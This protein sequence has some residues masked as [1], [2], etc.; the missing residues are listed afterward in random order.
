MSFKFKRKE[1]IMEGWIKIYRQIRNHWIWKDKEPFDKRSA[2]IDLLLSVNH[3][4]KKVPFENDFIEIERGQTLTSIKQLA[5]RWSWSR[6]KVSDY[7]NQLEQDTMIVQVR[8]TRKTLISIVNY[9][10]YQPALEE[11]DILGDTLRDRLG[12]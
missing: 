10:K 9:S 4:S 7:L 6:H 11:K 12:T 5:E 3:K 1:K 2:W 8:D